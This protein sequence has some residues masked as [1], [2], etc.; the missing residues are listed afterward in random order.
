MRE[1]QTHEKRLA[2]EILAENLRRLRGLRDLSQSDLAERMTALGHRWLRQ[3]VTD[4]ERRGRVVNIDELIGL[5]LALQ[6]SI[7][8]LLDPEVSYGPQAPKID[9]GTEWTLPFDALMAVIAQGS[10]RPYGG[11]GWPTTQVQWDGNAASHI[12]TTGEMTVTQEE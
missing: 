6:T 7:A 10:Q 11:F 12:I 1:P 4:V 3:T 9:V 5:A 8:G 2:S